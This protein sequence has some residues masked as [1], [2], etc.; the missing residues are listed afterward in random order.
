MGDWELIYRL[1]DLYSTQQHHFFP[2][3]LDV[4]A[5]S[6]LATIIYLM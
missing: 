5:I 6:D 4:M 3:V 2:M 1:I